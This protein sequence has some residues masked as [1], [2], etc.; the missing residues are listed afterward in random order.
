MRADSIYW[1]LIVVLTFPG[2]LRFVDY[3]STTQGFHKIVTIY[4]RCIPGFTEFRE[5]ES[6]GTLHGIKVLSAV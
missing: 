4:G 1:Q 3:E 6:L 2:H 5:S